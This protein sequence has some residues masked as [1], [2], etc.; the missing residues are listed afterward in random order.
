MSPHRTIQAAMLGLAAVAGVSPH[1]FAQDVCGQ[2]DGLVE[3][4][5]LTQALE[6]GAPTP[7]LAPRL[8][9]VVA[10]LSLPD[11]IPG[12]PDALPTDQ[13]RAL[14]GYVSGLR[15]A[16]A[17]IQNGHDAHARLALDGRVTPQLFA[18]LSS[19]E[20]RW[21]CRT[22]A[23]EAMDP[24][25]DLGSSLGARASEG[26]QGGQNGGPSSSLGQA[27]NPAASGTP[28]RNR[29]TASEPSGTGAYF[30]RGAI[31]RADMMVFVMA[32][33]GV[34]LAA[35]L[36]L[37]QRRLR[38]RTVRE[39]RRMLDRPVMV[40]MNGS[41]QAMR[42]IDVSMNGAKLGHGGTITDGAEIGIELGGNWH[43]AQ[44]R[45]TNAHYAGLKFKRPLDAATLQVL[46]RPRS[47]PHNAIP[48]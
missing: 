44:V 42:L 30:G 12:G 2:L 43:K 13:R 11:L 22:D 19:L 28:G 21:S 5:S 26:M 25:S 37:A 3:S 47:V 39:A 24:N 33:L 16:A 40:F 8:D 32:V 46:T 34:L 31:V 18:S 36:F 9:R 10:G 6:I 41:S 27:A 45:W 14:T 4:L 48:I 20:A 17:N 23:P 7:D 35:F 29:P 15:E 1:A 38:R